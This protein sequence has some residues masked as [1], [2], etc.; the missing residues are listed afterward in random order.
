MVLADH[1]R[2]PTTAIVGRKPSGAY[3][4]ID[5]HDDAVEI[6]GMLIWRSYAPLVFLNSRNLSMQ[7]R[8][9]VGQRK[10]IRVFVLDATAASG[11]D[12]TAIGAFGAAQ[13]D[14][15]AAGVA[16][17]IVNVREA[18]WKRVVAKFTAAGKPIPPRFDSLD[19]AVAQFES[20]GGAESGSDR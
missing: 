2:R 7:L 11:I 14:L 1:I 4:D 3:V 20:S 16:L 5:D 12:T 6:A 15:A 19:D 18:N 13:D 10:D 9:L 17:W 8:A